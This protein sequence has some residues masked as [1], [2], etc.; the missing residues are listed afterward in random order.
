MYF[1]KRDPMATSNINNLKQ[2]T[3]LLTRNCNLRCK[4]CFEKN[5]GYDVRDQMSFE[6]SEEGY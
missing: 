5:A 4:F 1:E 6:G 3:V 2:A